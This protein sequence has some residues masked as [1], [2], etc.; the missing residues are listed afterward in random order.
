MYL[1]WKAYPERKGLVC[2][3]IYASNGFGTI[4]NNISS[5]YLINP[6]NDL[7]VKETKYEMHAYFGKSVVSNVPKFFQVFA[8]AEFILLILAMMLITDNESR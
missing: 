1:G 7:P 5:T 2:S 6:N 3:L 4:V 8:L